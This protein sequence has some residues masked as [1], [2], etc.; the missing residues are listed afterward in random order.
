MD[1]KNENIF[2]MNK[3]SGEVKSIWFMKIFVN[4]LLNT[5]LYSRVLSM[6][7]A[8]DESTEEIY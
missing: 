1:V 5:L 4:N 6:K 8:I 3:I 2:K 7:I